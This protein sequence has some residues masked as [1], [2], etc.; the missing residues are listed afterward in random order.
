MFDVQ[1]YL[2]SKG[3]VLKPATGSEMHTACVYCGEMQGKRGRLYINVDST[4]E[5]L[6]LFYCHLCGEKGA[7]NKLRKFYGDP[8]LTDK[9]EP[10]GLVRKHSVLQEA[11]QYYHELLGENEEAYRYLVED[12]GL[13][14]E[15]IQRHQLGWADGSL[16]THL[17]SIG[18]SVEDAMSSGLTKSNGKD[19]LFE[20]I[21]IP[22]HSL[23]AVNMI[24]GKEIGGK[25]LTPPGEK[26]RL[27]NVDSTYGADQVVVTEGEFDAMVVEQMGYHAVGVPGA[28]SW[29]DSW[30]TYFDKVRK[31]Y[32]VFD[33]DHAGQLG[34]DKVAKA[35]GSKS[36]IVMM[37][38]ARPGEP[39]NDPS[40]WLVKK[41]HTKE[42]FHSL[43]TKSR[44]G[45]VVSVD[46][47]F[48]EWSEVQ[49]LDGLKFGIRGLD[50]KIAPGLLPA[51]V[52][53][54]LAKTGVGK[55]I[56]LLNMFYRV[57][58]ADPDAT[59]LFLSLEQTRGEWF[60]RAR[61]IHRFYHP[62]DSDRDCLPF[63]RNRLMIVDQNRVT[64]D[65]LISCID[66]FEFDLGKKPSLVAI[67]YLGYWARSYKGEPYERTGQAIMAVKAIA[68]DRR[69]PFITP[70]QVSRV[71]RF[72]EEIEADNARDS[73]VVEETADFMLGL[74]S[75]DNRKGQQASERTGKLELKIL[76]SRHGGA[77]SRIPMQFA[78]LSLTMIPV[79][80][81]FDL[82]NRA[83]S[84]YAMAAR[85][86]DFETA[87]YRHSTG[88][89]R[90]F[91]PSEDFDV[92]K[93]GIL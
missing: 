72:G 86:D 76:K 7:L 73:G 65:E 43:L 34:A 5:P 1:G 85:G 75:P 50:A 2:E 37:P 84:E 45:I 11:A 28:S 35:I 93:K 22:F 12:R 31:V 6:G 30:N 20:K 55:T 60:E 21:T 23:G 78:P 24:R 77:S 51:Q 38:E 46:D 19:F 52:M 36:R 48:L 81:D 71:A 42:E 91:I 14:L 18:F 41:G 59:I 63:Y 39:K 40:E 62:E 26:A 16:T 57:L 58:A 56:F 69:I 70:H 29:Q 66:Q 33:N 80:D 54:V 13:T 82:E 90:T 67:D 47:S 92:W 9:E 17:R 74:W 79:G 61:R 27:F 64:E 4:N 25:Y 15:T 87:I 10:Q 89:D 44:G 53:V 88:D 49:G 3:M 68:K 8:P 32:V 83:R